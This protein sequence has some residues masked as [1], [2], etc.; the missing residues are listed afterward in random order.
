MIDPFEVLIAQLGEALHL[1][2]F[3]DRHEACMLRIHHVL[4]VQLQMDRSREKLLAAAFIYELPPGR[5]REDVLCEALKA[6]GLPD[7]RPGIF[8]Y[9]A[10]ENKLVLYAD[11]LITQI[12]AEKLVNLLASLIDYAQL[13]REA[14]ERGS[15]SPAPVQSS[16]KNP[17]PFHVTSVKRIE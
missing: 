14:L 8:C 10:A 17:N 11:A 3:I 6:N 16:I 1:E 15:P 12:T 7:P 5:F 4:P 13:W 9:V 2:L